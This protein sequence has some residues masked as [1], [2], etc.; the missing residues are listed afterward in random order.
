MTRRI[1]YGLAGLVIMMAVL[2]A[3][4]A[5]EGADWKRFA[6]PEGKFSLELPP[7]WKLLDK[8]PD[9]LLA[10]AGVQEGPDDGFIEN[11]TIATAP[12]SP[13]RT[14]EDFWEIYLRSV[15]SVIDDYKFVGEGEL[16]VDGRLGRK[17]VFTG[18]LEGEPIEVMQAVFIKGDDVFILTFT[19]SP[20]TFD[21]R[22]ADFEHS[23]L[24]LKFE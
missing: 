10:A 9:V 3:T 12:N 7:D 13:P 18:K 4:A 17:L 16:T 21:R 22:Q 14:I 2:A 23:A 20:T 24:S 6:C 19:D 8:I 11:L 15:P 5:A 1:I